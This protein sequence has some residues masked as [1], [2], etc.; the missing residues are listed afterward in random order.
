[1]PEPLAILGVVR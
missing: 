1:M